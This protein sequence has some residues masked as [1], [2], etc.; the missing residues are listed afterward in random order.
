M[1][2][3]ASEGIKLSLPR[4]EVARQGGTPLEFDD[5][6]RAH[7]PR[8]I[9]LLARIAGDRARAEELASEV[10]CRLASRPLLFAP[11][12]NLVPWMSRTRQTWASTRCAWKRGAA[13]TSEP[14]LPKRREP[15]IPQ[16]RSRRFCA[17]SASGASVPLFLD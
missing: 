9:R 8:V 7:Y 2:M 4:A 16:I 11:G 15:Q 3:G 6:F 10:L 13:G 17:G 12:N 5:A 1:N 14:R